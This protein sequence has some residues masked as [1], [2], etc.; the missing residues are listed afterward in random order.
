[1]LT[2]LLVLGSL[3]PS[4]ATASSRRPSADPAPQKAPAVESPS[5]RAPDPAPQA[6]PKSPPSHSTS[7]GTSQT[8]PTV[9]TAGSP[10]IVKLTAP[11]R[12]IST[13][14]AAPLRPNAASPNVA[15]RS[16]TSRAVARAVRHHAAV[17]HAAH[18]H[19]PPATRPVAQPIS[20][21]VLRGLLPTHLLRVPALQSGGG[22]H[23][24]GVL[25]L[26]CS[27]AMAVL[28]VSSFSLL[29]RLKRLE[30]R[31]R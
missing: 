12:P 23:P 26:L 28:A 25:L 7:S 8:R 13:S 2:L 14:S 6:V 17:S 10:H 9:I 16:T 22:N 5:T 3:G 24:D 27:L 15:A 19:A 29:R 4:A 1:M 20:L 11:G 31:T 30:V 18:H 21:S